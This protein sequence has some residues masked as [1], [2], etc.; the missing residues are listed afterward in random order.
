MHVSWPHCA[1]G[2]T[3]VTYGGGSRKGFPEWHF[4]GPAASQA[5]S[6]KRECCLSH[7]GQCAVELSSSVAIVL[8]RIFG[9][10]SWKRADVDQ[11]GDLR[12]PQHIGKLF[13]A[14]V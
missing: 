14:A 2:A 8:S 11:Q 7:H 5:R 9:A 1:L 4:A 12:R 10:G 3:V 13:H 6:Q